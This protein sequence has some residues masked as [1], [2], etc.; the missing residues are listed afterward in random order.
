M[1]K[2]LHQIANS[3]KGL[4]RLRQ[5]LVRGYRSTI[6][7]CFFS[8]NIMFGKDAPSNFDLLYGVDLDNN[9]I[10]GCREIEAAT[11][12]NDDVRQEAVFRDIRSPFFSDRI[13]N[14]TMK[15][16][17][18]F[19]LSIVIWTNLFCRLHLENENVDFTENYWPFNRWKIM[20]YI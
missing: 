10:G 16:Y 18:L 19:S 8:S 7:L 4:L 11:T 14:R 9:Q 13:A 5:Q 6:F 3:G 2:Y 17:F 15:K 1:L 12:E 20:K